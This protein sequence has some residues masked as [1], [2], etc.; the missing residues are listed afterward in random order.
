MCV[1]LGYGPGEDSLRP[2]A[3]KQAGVEPRAVPAL[4]QAPRAVQRGQR[5]EG[6]G[7]RISRVQYQ[8]TAPTQ[9]VVFGMALLILGYSLLW[10]CMGRRP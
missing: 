8:Y 10:R 3:G 9:I 7:D 2:A 5:G 4:V 6:D 1:L